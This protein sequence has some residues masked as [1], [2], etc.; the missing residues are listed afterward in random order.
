MKTPSVIFHFIFIVTAILNFSCTKQPKR[1]STPIYGKESTVQSVIVEYTFAIHPLHNSRRYFEVYQPLVDYINQHT[2]EFSVRLEASKDYAHFEEKL[3]NRKFQ[4][5]IPNP[6]QSI[7]SLQYGYTIFGK[8]GDDE[9]FR[10]IIVVRK[11]S[12]I[13]SIEDLRGEV[14]SFPSATALAAA[15]MPKYFLKTNGLDVEK[16]AKC[17]YVGSQ[18][19]SIM[20]VYFGKTKAGCTWPPPWE[21]F[22]KD[23]PEVDSALTIQWQT[24]PLINNGLVVR[25]DVPEQHCKIFFDILFQLHT[26][27]EGK[28]IL[29]RINLSRFVPMLQKEYTARVNTFLIK[30]KNLF[31]SLPA[32]GGKK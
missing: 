28:E 30:Y 9:R 32:M 10:G 15:M 6:Y 8:M 22:L 20:N 7:Q 19:S 17:L 26:H 27:R 16:D 2:K 11:D 3:K 29:K 23:H 1:E 4:F 13:R 31:G 5:A 25:N 24:E 14:I 18:E 21:S 12:H